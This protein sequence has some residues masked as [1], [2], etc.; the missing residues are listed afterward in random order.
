MR[1]KRENQQQDKGALRRYLLFVVGNEPQGGLADVERDFDKLEA[2]IVIGKSRLS[3]KPYIFDC[4][5]RKV[6]WTHKDN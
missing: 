5:Q 1:K 4:D 2:A 6:V 3:S